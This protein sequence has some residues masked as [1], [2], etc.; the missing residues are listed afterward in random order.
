M[1]ILGIIPI[2]K[3]IPSTLVHYYSMQPALP[4]ECAHIRYGNREI[5]GVIMQVQDAR[6]LKA[7]IKRA[8]FHLKPIIQVLPQALVHPACIQ[9]AF[10]LHTLYHIPLRDVLTT[11][12]PKRYLQFRIEHDVKWSPTQETPKKNLRDVPPEETS[13]KKDIIQPLQTSREERIAYYRTLIREYFSYNQSVLIILP[14]Q[15][16]V[17]MY[18]E[19]LSRGIESHIHMFHG[20][21]SEAHLIAEW[22]KCDDH[23]DHPRVLIATPTFFSSLYSDSVGVCCI[24]MAS[25]PSYYSYG[26][27]IDMAEY[28]AT[29]CAKSSLR[30]IV[31]DTLLPLFII[32]RAWDHIYEPSLPLNFHIHTEAQVHTLERPSGKSEEKGA[33][34]KEVTRK[35]EEWTA[36]LPETQKLMGSV[37]A[38]D[39]PGTLSVIFVPRKGYASITVCNECGKTVSCPTCTTPLVLHT[40]PSRIYKCHHCTYTKKTSTR[41]DSCTSERLA[42]LGVTTEKVEEEL[43]TWISPAVSCLRMDGDGEVSEKDLDKFIASCEKDGTAGILIGTQRILPYLHTYP[44]QNLIIPSLE[45]LLARPDYEAEQQVLRLLVEMSTPSMTNIIV[46]TQPHQETRILTMLTH[47]T[48]LQEVR[49]ELALREQYNY[50]PFVR[51]LWLHI[52][53]KTTTHIPASIAEELIKTFVAFQARS[54]HAATA[55]MRIPAGSYIS[56]KIPVQQYDEVLQN[57]SQTCTRLNIPEYRIYTDGMWMV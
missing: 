7:D 55:S 41:C 29:A 54:E 47:K 17:R 4:G 43:R 9:A 36:I 38:Y 40:S 25:S 39:K 13:Q 44:F 52:G 49:D 53:D 8:S 22:Q 11:V 6:D 12:I 32:K 5:I 24:E 14:T 26:T 56:M 20:G 10:L 35:K 1:Y 46:Q 37:C 50:P 15:R 3:G 23:A 33:I 21:R 42:L 28:I 2:A 19:E 57:I 45:T 34:P 16:D 31:G 48:M 18:A 30:C 27:H 51:H